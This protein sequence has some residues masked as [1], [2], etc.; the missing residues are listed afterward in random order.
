M[1][2]KLTP[3]N[4]HSPA[5]NNIAVSDTCCPKSTLIRSPPRLKM[6]WLCTASAANTVDR[7]MS[8]QKLLIF[9]LILG[10]YSRGYTPCGRATD[11]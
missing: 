7:Q 6:T 8:S 4:R 10:D 11:W 2:V 3:P 1:A 9:S 5:S